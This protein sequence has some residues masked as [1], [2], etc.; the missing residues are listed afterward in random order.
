MRNSGSLLG[1]DELDSHLPERRL[2][3]F[4]ATWNMHEDKVSFKGDLC[5][6]WFNIS[7]VLKGL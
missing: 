7:Y 4:V 1:K 2:R 5:F 6:G 3:I